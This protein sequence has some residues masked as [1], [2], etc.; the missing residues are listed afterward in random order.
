MDL[1]VEVFFL[2]LNY[3]LKAPTLLIMSQ[4]FESLSSCFTEIMDFKVAS[5]CDVTPHV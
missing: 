5:N 1:V 4:N 3:F 2:I